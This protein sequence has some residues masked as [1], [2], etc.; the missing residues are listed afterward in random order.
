[1]KQKLLLARKFLKIKY[2]SYLATEVFRKERVL[3]GRINKV[4]LFRYGTF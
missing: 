4:L 1:M 3:L 2:G